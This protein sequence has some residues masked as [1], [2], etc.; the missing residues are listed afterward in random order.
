[1]EKIVPHFW[2]DN[3][4]KEA[5]DFY[6]SLFEDSEM[7][8]VQE[9]EDTPSGDD[10]IAYEFNLA[11]QHFAA[12][13]GGPL[14]KINPS[15]SLTVLGDTNEEI[16]TL[17]DQLIDGGEELMPLQ[18]YDFS[19]FY[20]WVEDK[21]GLSWQLISSEG[22]EYEQKII[23]SLMFSGST[24]GNARDAMT[25]YT[26]IFQGGEIIDVYE[27]EEGQ[28]NTPEAEIAHATFKIM[29]MELIAAD[30][31]E[32]VDY[33]FNE[34]V[35]LMIMC[36]TQAEIDYYW[37]KLSAEPEAEQCGWLK[38][39]F[40]LSWQVVPMNLSE[41]LSTGTRKQINAVTQAFLPMKK[42]EIEKLE[43]VWTS[44]AE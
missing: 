15:I 17:W 1:M 14:F 26:N 12:L 41:L 40:G 27:Y 39:K 32:D 38:D 9:L 30:N 34:A 25:Y 3:N 35:S 7:L 2:F 18:K 16:Q 10:T 37:E 6:M 13:N 20:G 31:G 29:D 43:R 23:P 5:V 11:G 8:V 21:Y 42:I 36:V 22:M 28:A 19:E 4:A 24:N 44:A 33:E